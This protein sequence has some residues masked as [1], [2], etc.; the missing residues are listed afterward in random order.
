[1]RFSRDQCQKAGIIS[2]RVLRKPRFLRK[3]APLVV[4]SQDAIDHHFTDCSNGFQLDCFDTRFAESRPK[5]EGFLARGLV[6]PRG[7]FIL[8]SYLSALKYDKGRCALNVEE[9]DDLIKNLTK[10]QDS[11]HS[12][13]VAIDDRYVA[14]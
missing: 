10:T 13:S 4:K 5:W 6:Y 8:D 14:L 2:K 11:E 9:E 7:Y 3:H 12:A 1:M